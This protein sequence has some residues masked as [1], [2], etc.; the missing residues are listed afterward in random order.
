MPT[1]TVVK[2]YCWQIEANER[3]KLAKSFLDYNTQERIPY[4]VS[5]HIPHQ[6]GRKVQIL[7][8]DNIS[9]IGKF[10]K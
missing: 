1:P 4:V 5:V 10:V 6:G 2:L 9:N 7:R 8:G 3:D